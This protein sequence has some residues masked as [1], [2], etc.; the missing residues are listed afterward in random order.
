M[1]TISS[2]HLSWTA[3]I[4]LTLAA[5]AP[6]DSSELRST[7]AEDLT[8]F[9]SVYEY[10]TEANAKV[11][12]ALE[13]ASGTVINFDEG[14]TF[15][16]DADTE[17][18]VS[19]A[20][21]LSNGGLLNLDY[22]YDG[23]IDKTITDGNY[24]ITYTDADGLQTTASMQSRETLEIT[25]INDGDTISTNSFTVTWDPISITGT[26]SITATYASGGVIGIHTQTVS[27]TGSA[28]LDL[29]GFVGT[30]EIDL[31]HITTTGFAEGF[32]DVTL[33]MRNISKREVNYAIPSAGIP[34]LTRQ[35]S[36]EDL[37]A[38]CEHVCETGEEEALFIDDIRYECCQ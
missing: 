34:T 12:A 23:S 26:L 33:T 18:G 5:C 6:V 1:Q 21:F 27:N 8:L 37:Q 15:S 32:D 17:N 14:Q 22:S 4:F 16:T 30:G 13:T 28:I 29:T 10:S 19:S 7:K 24:H 38:G 11:S 3:L 2:T 35:L 31:N 20:H 36:P 25:D 9:A